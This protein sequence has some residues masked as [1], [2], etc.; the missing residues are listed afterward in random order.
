MDDGKASFYSICFVGVCSNNTGCFFLEIFM[1]YVCGLLFSS[2]ALRC[3]S[4]L[5]ADVIA[6]T[7][8]SCPPLNPSSVPVLRPLSF[9][10]SSF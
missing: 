9:P 2:D 4:L 1:S 5:H 7:L 10:L 6:Y 8:L 3:F